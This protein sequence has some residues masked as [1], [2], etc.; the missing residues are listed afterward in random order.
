MAE[1]RA[2]DHT[3]LIARLLSDP[4][5]LP[6]LV[7]PLDDADA[8]EVVDRL[9]QEAD[10]HWAIN[11]NRSLE[12]AE[13]IIAIGQARGDRCQ[14][15]LGTMARGD[16]LKLIGRTEEDRKSTRLNSSH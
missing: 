4:A 5:G 12:L 3:D 1:K 14:L 13:L 9:K 2:M 8:A 10:R 7:V 15:A 11:A 16:A 6:A